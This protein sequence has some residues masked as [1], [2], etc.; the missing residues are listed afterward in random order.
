M[1]QVESLISAESTASIAR[2]AQAAL[3]QEPKAEGF[4]LPI[5]T[6]TELPDC[7][8]DQEKHLA[9][10]VK[11]ESAAFEDDEVQFVFSVPKRRK[12]RRKE[13]G[14]HPFENLLLKA[15]FKL[16]KKLHYIRLGRI[17]M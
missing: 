6:V 2:P 7:Q 11:R 12:K 16:A 10:K 9:R 15:Y 13:Y 1:A 8:S 17:Y 5:T 4:T 14:S 3:E